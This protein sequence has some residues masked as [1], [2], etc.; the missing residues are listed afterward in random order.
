MIKLSQS[1]NRVKPSASLA[2]VARVNEL[3]AQGRDIVSFTVGEPDFDTP[4]HIKDAA[5]EAMKKGLTK[6]TPVA[7]ILELRKVIAEKLKREQQIEVTP[8][9]IVVTNGGKQALTAACAVLLD[10][11]DEAIIPA[12][13]WTSY[14]DMVLL[15]GGTPVIVPTV[16]EQGYVMTPEMLVRAASSKTKMIIIN[17]PSNPTGACYTAQQLKGLAEAIKSLPNAKDIVIVLDDVYEYFAYD[18]FKYSSFTA[19]CPEL[20]PNTVL[21]NAFSK[22]YAMTGWRVGY[23]TGPKDIVSA[24]D[25]HQSQFT[26]NVCSIAQWA[27]SAAYNDNGEFPK[28]MAAEFQTRLDILCEQVKQIPGVALPVKPQGAF[29]AFLRVDGLFGKR[30]GDITIK[31][32]QD[33]SNYLLERFDVATVAGEAFGDANAI[34][35]SFALSREKMLEGLRRIKQ[36]AVSL[37]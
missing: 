31:S 4:Q 23:V 26:S 13:Y 35:L 19:L 25:K 18:G 11:G 6:Y 28:K 7:G 17:S 2:A 16:A 30:N 24:I 36:A 9:D 34:R 22:S 5:L 33:F 20:L 8:K 21:V 10:Q 1:I 27:A 32:G 37:S 29:Y 14:P 15:A 3:K 12:P